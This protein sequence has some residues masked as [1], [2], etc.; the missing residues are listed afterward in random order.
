MI[1]QRS[2]RNAVRYGAVFDPEPNGR[3]RPARI[4][5]EPQMITP[6]DAAPAAA[7]RPAYRLRWLAAAVMI[8]GALMDMIDLT[9][10][11]VA[12]PTVRRDL[13]A[14]ATELE[15]VISG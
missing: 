5:E 11:N 4:S 8:V 3:G 15:W 1:E 10:V 14:G 7:E 6:P 13:H 9:I 12:L 2:I